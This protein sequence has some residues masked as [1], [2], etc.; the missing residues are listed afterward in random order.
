MK[1]YEKIALNFDKLSEIHLIYKYKTDKI[2]AD[3]IN[4]YI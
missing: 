1:F 2:Y 4:K 3:Y